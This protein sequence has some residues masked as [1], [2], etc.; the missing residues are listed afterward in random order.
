ML[1][2]LQCYWCGGLVFQSIGIHP[3]CWERLKSFAMSESNIP[4]K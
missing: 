2:K 3:H 4:N 1:N